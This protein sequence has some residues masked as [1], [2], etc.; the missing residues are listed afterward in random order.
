MNDNTLDNIF[1]K[2]FSSENIIADDDSLDEFELKL[3]K[4]M[5]YKFSWLQFNVYYMSMIAACFL[6]SSFLVINH[7]F[8][9]LVNSENKNVQNQI[10]HIDSISSDQKPSLSAKEILSSKKNKFT[11]ITPSK[12]DSTYHNLSTA[13]VSNSIQDSISIVNTTKSNS[14]DVPSPATPVILK[15]KKTVYLCSP[16]DTIIKIDT[17]ILKKGRKK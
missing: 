5:F 17:V 7:F 12:E 13:I 11:S 14:N 16:R 9:P 10:S 8:T 1:K 4:K 15:R 6:S 3:H 2:T